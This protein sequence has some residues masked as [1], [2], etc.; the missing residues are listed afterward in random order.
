ME[1]CPEIYLTYVGN[2]S[3][4]GYGSNPYHP[5]HFMYWTFECFYNWLTVLNIRKAPRFKLLALWFGI[6]IMMM[7]FCFV[8]KGHGLTITP[9][10]AGH[11]VGGAMWKII[12]DGEEVIIYA[13]DYNHKKER[14]VSSLCCCG[15]RMSVPPPPSHAVSPSPPCCPPSPPMLFLPPCCPPSPPMLFLPLMS[16]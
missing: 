13:V 6:F 3:N 2:G 16:C 10:A 14:L 8:G 7:P 12:K 9:H 1:Q 15:E 4:P 11:M 5:Q